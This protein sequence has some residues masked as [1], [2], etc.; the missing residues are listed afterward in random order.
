MITD[1]IFAELATLARSAKGADRNLLDAI[2]AS[3][4]VAGGAAIVGLSAK[5]AYTALARMRARRAKTAAVTDGQS[6]LTLICPDVHVP[7]HDRRAVA[8]FRQV[9][10]ELRPTR[11][12]FIGDMVDMY[13]ISSYARDP[14]RKAKLNDELDAT[15]ELLDTFD[16]LQIDETIF[17][18]GNHET[19]LTRFVAAHCPEL[20]TYIPT[21]PHMLRIAERGWTWVPYGTHCERGNMLYS[22]EFGRCGKYAGHQG[23]T[24]V[25]GNIT[26]GHSHRL[27]V[28][29]GGTVAGVTH[30]AL[31]VGWLGDL[32]EIDYRHK[33]LAIREWQQGFGAVSESA[34]GLIFAQAVP[35][36]DYTCCVNGR[37]FH[38]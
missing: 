34:N 28:S 12:V 22:H 11:L 23:L 21:V 1:A 20:H 32:R 19:R 16:K 36:V 8:L 18:E 14:K 25:G 3:R 27:S 37:V 17:C 10:A 33:T 29:Y 5:G 30:V 31:N 4:D 2:R 15:N 9:V 38:G 7:Y 26:F 6:S 13:P 24:D 35:I